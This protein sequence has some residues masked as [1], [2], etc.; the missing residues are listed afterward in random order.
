MT[1]LPGDLPRLSLIAFIVQTAWCSAALAQSDVFSIQA[2]TYR[3]MATQEYWTPERLANA[4]TLPLPI[5]PSGTREGVAMP[6]G[7]QPASKAAVNPAGAGVATEVKLFERSDYPATEALEPSSVVDDYPTVESTA[8]VQPL[9]AGT[10]QAPFTSARLASTS[11]HKATLYRKVGRLFFTKPGQGDFVCSASVIGY[12]I[13]VTAGHCVHKGSGGAGG[14]YTNWLFVPAYKDGTAPYQAWNWSFA[15]TTATWMSGGGV[16]PNAADY[17]MLV[18]SDRL[19]D[20]QMKKIGAVTGMLGWKTLSLSRNHVHMLGYP[21]NLDSCEQMHQ[22]TAGDF[23]DV[24]PNNVEYG[25][26]MRGGSSG[27]PWIQNFGTASSGQTGGLNTTRNAVVGITSYG[28]ISTDPKVAGSSIPDSRW[29]SLWN[30]VCAQRAG[31][32]TK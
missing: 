1:R 28:Y 25:S 27:G 7:L 5:A 32:C 23:Q 10:A 21:C 14:W 24:A 3:T 16:V 12:R 11:L 2:S 30:S 15:A 9:D 19:I 6:I 8:S 18:M 20:S 17:A 31:N 26:D 13:I 4:R 29:V 22:V